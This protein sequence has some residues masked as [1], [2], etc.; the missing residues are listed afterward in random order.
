KAHFHGDA[1]VNPTDSIA[2]RPGTRLGFTG[3]Q[4]FGIKARYT[5]NVKDWPTRFAC[6]WRRS[7]GLRQPKLTHQ[8][9]SVR[10]V[11]DFCV[12]PQLQSKNGLVQQSGAEDVIPGN[13]YKLRR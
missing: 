11:G 12:V 4:G 3:A 6:R 9:S 10:R 13:A 7:L 1:A 8:G 2:G 5:G